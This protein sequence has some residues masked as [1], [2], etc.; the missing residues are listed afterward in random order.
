MPSRSH[1]GARPWRKCPTV[2]MAAYGCICREHGAY[3]VSNCDKPSL[4]PS[5]RPTM[6]PT[7]NSPPH[8]AQTTPSTAPQLLACASRASLTEQRRFRGRRGRRIATDHLGRATKRSG[9]VAQAVPSTLPCGCGYS[10]HRSMSHVRRSAL[11]RT[12]P[13]A[14]H[15]AAIATRTSGPHPRRR[16]QLAAPCAAPVTSPRRC[17]GVRPAAV[18]PLPPAAR[19]AALPDSARLARER[20]PPLLAASV[21]ALSLSVSLR[22][23]L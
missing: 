16:P 9:G 7:P 6:P 4:M 1:H 12:A 2:R 23:R 20:V 14:R 11:P 21:L 19:S 3:A 22:N 18:R 5:W 8:L 10:T 15:S 17:A 13:R